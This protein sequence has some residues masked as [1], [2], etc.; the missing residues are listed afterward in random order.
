MMFAI[1]L[2]A[3]PLA[4]VASRISHLDK[5]SDEV[6]AGTLLPFECPPECWQ[7]C[8]SNDRNRFFHF[9]TSKV[10][11]K[12]VLKNGSHLPRNHTCEEGVKRS[13]ASHA[14]KTYCE[15]NEGEDS[16]L[17]EDKCATRSKAAK[18]A[19]WL[20][21][22]KGEIFGLA[23]RNM[24]EMASIVRSIRKQA[25][26]EVR[27]LPLSQLSSIHPVDER[28]AIE[29]TAGRAR[30][31]VAARDVLDHS[32]YTMTRTII[33]NYPGLKEFQSISGF[34]VVKLADEE[35][36]TF[37]GNGRCVAL[38]WAFPEGDELRHKLKIEVKEFIIDDDENKAEIIRRIRALQKA[39]GSREFSSSMRPPSLDED[40]V[41]KW[42]QGAKKEL[43]EL[44]DAAA[45]ADRG[46]KL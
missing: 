8:A 9:G 3:L 43:K 5:V 25:R 30:A 1:L 40:V 22:K 39:M 38:Q 28:G 46:G 13:H 24:V 21:Q 41:A 15:F 2:A 20:W 27:M 12:C 18:L 26:R 31:A 36:V 29:K 6:S 34:Y 35:Y 45:A 37:E 23:N 44:M 32:P 19:S 4:G 17:P 14:F 16:N 10:E 11:F 33:A 42:A 7:C